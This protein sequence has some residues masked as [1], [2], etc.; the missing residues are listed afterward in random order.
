MLPVLTH[1]IHE[2]FRLLFKVTQQVWL[3]L[4][5]NIFIQLTMQ[6]L[7]N[8]TYFDLKICLFLCIF[9][10]YKVYSFRVSLLLHYIRL[11]LCTSDC[12]PTYQ[13]RQWYCYMY[14]YLILNTINYLHKP[15]VINLNAVFLKYFNVVKGCKKKNQ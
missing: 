13:K 7:T 5:K 12:L 2:E 1:E 14:M 15:K 3:S 4:T 10:C 9:K 6:L 8:Q 11:H